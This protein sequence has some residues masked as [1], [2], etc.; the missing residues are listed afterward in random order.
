MAL[1]SLALAPAKKATF[2][3]RVA[4]RLLW[5]RT[6]RAELELAGARHQVARL[7][8]ERDRARRQ[9]AE[10]IAALEDVSRA[11]AALGSIGAPLAEIGP[12]R[13]LERARPAP[14]RRMSRAKARTV[15]R[16][17]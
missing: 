16:V 1:A 8:L 11:L 13:P 9:A 12:L 5:L 15:K 10:A 14:R 2:P 17:A 6:H 4:L 7:R 3:A